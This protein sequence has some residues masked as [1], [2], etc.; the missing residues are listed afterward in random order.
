MD[1]RNGYLC[2]CVLGYT[3]VNCEKGTLVVYLQCTANWILVYKVLHF[4]VVSL[5]FLSLFFEHV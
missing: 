5:T 1:L 4:T 3:G 2:A